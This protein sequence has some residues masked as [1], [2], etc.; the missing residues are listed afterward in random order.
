MFQ[1]EVV[2]HIIVIYQ[3]IPNME[4][5]KNESQ[6]HPRAATTKATVVG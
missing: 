6:N 5:A 1:K 2:Y 4:F 3:K